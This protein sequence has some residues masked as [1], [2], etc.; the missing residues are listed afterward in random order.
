MTKTR[1]KPFIA[2]ALFAAMAELEASMIVTELGMV[3]IPLGFRVYAR[4]EG[5]GK[6]VVI[7]SLY[8]GVMY[9]TVSEISASAM[10]LAIDKLDQHQ[11]GIHS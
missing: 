8:D 6:R 11:R 5:K 3:F 10:L 1:P 2:P 4:P 9:G 7:G